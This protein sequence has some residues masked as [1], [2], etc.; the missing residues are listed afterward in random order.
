[1]AMR[2]LVSAKEKLEIEWENDGNK[3]YVELIVR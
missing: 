2:I 1:M 3:K